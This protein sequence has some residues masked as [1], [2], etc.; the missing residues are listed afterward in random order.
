VPM[1]S[2]VRVWPGAQASHFVVHDEDG[3]T[4]TIDA[5]AM[6]GGAGEQVTLSRVVAATE[7]RVW[8]PSGLSV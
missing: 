6:N 7:L 3:A 1:R 4:T 5:Q 2:S 8:L